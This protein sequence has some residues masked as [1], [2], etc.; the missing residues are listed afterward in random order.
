MDKE[1]IED[2]LIRLDDKIREARGTLKDLSGARKELA[3][4]HRNVVSA[5]AEAH[6]IAINEVLPEY[7]TG[8][9]KAVDR[10]CNIATQK[11]Y[12]RFDTLAAIL[13]GEE[14]NKETLTEVVRRWRAQR[15]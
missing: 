7:M 6:R 12:K 9:K 14:G 4:T 11:V 2:L 3:Q 15:D 8:L 10:T 13:M 5:I 1:E